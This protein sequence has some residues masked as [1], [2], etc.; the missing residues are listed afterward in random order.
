[1]SFYFP[2][3][4][5]KNNV[6]A[7]LCITCKKEGK[8]KFLIIN[9][10]HLVLEGGTKE[11]SFRKSWKVKFSQLAGTKEVVSTIMQNKDELLEISR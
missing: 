4:L 8:N 9:S 10:R 7:R 11:I 5:N 3:L 6:E 2:T 1:M